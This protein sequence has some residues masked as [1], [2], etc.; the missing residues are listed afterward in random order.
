VTDTIEET[1]E[2]VPEPVPQ[3]DYHEMTRILMAEIREYGHP[4]TGWFVGRD[5]LLLT[6][7]GARSG[8]SRTVPLAYSRDGDAYVV[9]ASKGGAPTHPGWYFNILADPNG[10]IEVD[11]QTIKVRASVAEGAERQR[12]WDQHVAIHTGIGE[13]PQKT[14]RIIPVVVLERISD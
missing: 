2:G 8:A 14:D 5:V 1:V 9:T 12:L 13:Y 6:T 10:T 7:T 11:L 3:P 4:K